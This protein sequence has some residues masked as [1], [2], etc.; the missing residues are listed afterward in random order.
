LR[1]D[2]IKLKDNNLNSLKFLKNKKKDGEIMKR[3]AKE[4]LN[5]MS[6]VFGIIFILAGLGG[7]AI[8]IPTNSTIIIAPI[9]SLV[10]GAFLAIMGGLRKWG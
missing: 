8:A 3:D 5:L 4:T 6:L 2:I 10:L 1:E 9:I 7:S